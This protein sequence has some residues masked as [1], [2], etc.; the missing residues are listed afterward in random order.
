MQTNGKLDSAAR[1]L[2]KMRW[3]ARGGVI[4]GQKFVQKYLDTYRE[5]T[6]RRTRIP[7]RVFTKDSGDAWSAIHSMR[8]TR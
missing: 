8:G 3:F 6:K 2:L 7:P 1:L 4:G 5:K